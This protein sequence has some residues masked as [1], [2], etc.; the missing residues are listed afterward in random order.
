MSS[1]PVWLT[2]FIIHSRVPYSNPC[3]GAKLRDRQ[4]KV[5]PQA[6]PWVPVNWGSG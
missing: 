2:R 4:P 1:L 3:S 6:I 5:P